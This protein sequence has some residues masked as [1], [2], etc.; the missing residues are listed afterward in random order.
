MSLTTNNQAP[1]TSLVAHLYSLCSWNIST[2]YWDHVSSILW[3]LY[4]LHHLVVVLIVTGFYFLQFSAT[5]FEFDVW[6][7]RDLI[8]KKNLVDSA[9]LR[10]LILTEL[11]DSLWP[12]ESS[13]RQT[14]RCVL[15]SS[16]GMDFIFVWNV[17]NLIK[18]GRNIYLKCA[19]Y[20]KKVIEIEFELGFVS[21]ALKI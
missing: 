15:L 17:T 19:L 14:V 1:R 21:C 3:Q 16:V 18:A 4:F 20:I 11:Q 10:T 6:I 13:L 8:I 7:M 5:L 12:L 9:M 2:N